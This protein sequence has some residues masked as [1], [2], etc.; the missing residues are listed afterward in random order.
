[1]FLFLLRES[2]EE[3]RSYGDIGVVK[4]IKIGID[5]WMLIL[6]L[7]WRNHSKLI[8]MRKI[9]IFYGSS[10]GTTGDVAQRIA[11][12]LG[13]DS[14]DVHDVATVSPDSLL[15]YDCLLLGSST[16][17][18]GDLQDDWEGFL[19]KIGKLDLS[20]KLVALFG[21]GDSASFGD[22]FCDAIGTIH[23]GLKATGCQ[24]VGSM[25]PAGYSFEDSTALVDG[26]FV[27]L[28]VDEVNE[29]GQTDSRIDRWIGS[30]RES[31]G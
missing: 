27:G 15:S 12:K 8:D 5:Y 6:D 31:L 16:W 4:Y 26:Q 17:G 24:F 11:A 13:V 14:K 30:F 29:D 2:S 1:M 10:S 19:P 21:C 7:C 3:Y 23:D 9:G 25:D 28:L 18:S 20:G 22:T